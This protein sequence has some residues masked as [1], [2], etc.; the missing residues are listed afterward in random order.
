MRKSL[1]IKKLVLIFILIS[2]NTVLAEVTCIEAMLN[3]VDILVD[4][5]PINANSIIY[6]NTV[7]I[8]IGT[9][10][11]TMGLDIEYNNDEKEV[12]LKSGGI[13]HLDIKNKPREPK[14]KKI[15]IGFNNLK[16]YVDETELVNEN[17]IYESVAYL[18]LYE[19]A[20]ILNVE[21]KYDKSVNVI[22]IITNSSN[23]EVENMEYKVSITHN[24]IDYVDEPRTV[25]EFKKVFLYMVN[26]NITIH[27]LRYDD[28]YKALFVDSTEIEENMLQAF[29]EI[30]VEYVEYF[31][32]FN[33]VAYSMIGHT[34]SIFTIRLQNNNFNVE[35]IINKQ[36]Y[37]EKYANTINEYLHKE[38]II[39][40]KMNERV[41]AEN[42]YTYVTQFLEYDEELNNESY[43]GYGAV[44]NNK[45]VCQGYTA[46]YN[47]LLKLNNINCYGES[48][49]I[50]ESEVPHIWTVA[51]LDGKWTYIDVTF[52]DPVPDEKNYT[53]Y[54]YFDMDR[55]YIKESRRN[56]N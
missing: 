16:V 26:N 36:I 15:E 7:F 18:P 52:G 5:K 20:N 43:S 6:N 49:I 39:S 51:E 42:L 38:G 45:A 22:N 31:S 30:S 13:Q 10:S 3:N 21:T 37:F 47:Y 34:N 35:D 9:L 28:T 50:I 12:Y 17:I 2:T 48:G 44:K 53:N 23:N 55:E 8:P 40:T 14:R 41:V 46:L 32:G 29:N 4:Y 27:N 56:F 11:N 25:E 19:V 33:Q 1:L 54:D 24:D